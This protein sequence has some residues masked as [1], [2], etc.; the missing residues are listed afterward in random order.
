MIHCGG[1]FVMVNACMSAAASL[2][3]VAAVTW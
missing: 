1:P 3:W 2:S